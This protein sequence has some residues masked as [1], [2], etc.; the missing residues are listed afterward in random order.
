MYDI[1]FATSEA[2][3]LIKTGGLGDVAGSLPGALQQIGLQVTLMMPAYRAAV[4]RA[5]ELKE[6]TSFTVP[7]SAEPVRLLEG[8]LDDVRLWL[9]D[10]PYH[11]DRPGGPYA[12]PDGVD[13]PDN[14]QRFAVFGRAVTLAAL[15]RIGGWHP[16]VVHCNDWQ[17][18]LVP[19]LLAPEPQRPAT[20]FTVH[21]LAYHGL[22]P[23]ET[24]AALQLPFELWSMHAME[25]YNQFSFIKGGLVFADWI[26][27]VSPTYAQEIRTPEFGCGLDGLLNFRADRLVGI[28]N[29]V[30]YAVWD[31]AHDPHIARAYDARSLRNKAANKRALQA[32][33]GLAKESKP[34]L[35]GMV[36]RLVEQKGV[37]LL[38]ESIDWLMAREAQLAVLGTGHP[39]FEEALRAAAQRYP[40]RVGVEIGYDEQFAHLIEAGADLF[41]MPSRF[42]PCGLNQIYSLR[43]GT[44]PVVRRTGGLADTVVDATPAAVKA[45]EATG[46][47]FDAASAA[48]FQEAIDRALRLRAEQARAWGRVRTTAMAQDYSWQNSAQHYLELYQRAV[49]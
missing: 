2:H 25:F 39:P 43:Y 46:F 15:G 12:G 27:T 10:S 44:P 5:G 35:L 14:A 40:G 6:V 30:D 47:V 20:I 4:E 18:G 36:S 34:A 33:L 11:Y 21:N 16:D 49:G 22:F 19:A 9:V 1:L 48:G 8:R 32:K 37:D 45:G 26:T 41:L 29:G 28:L 17:S 23:W 38:L 3:P 24:F 13:W 31:P 7:G 42:E